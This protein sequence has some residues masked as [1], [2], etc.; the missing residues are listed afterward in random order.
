[1][2]FLDF[3]ERDDDR[4]D[5]MLLVILL[6]TLLKESGDLLFFTPLYTLLLTGLPLFSFVLCSPLD[7]IVT[8]DLFS[9]DNLDTIVLPPTTRSLEVIG[10][11]SESEPSYSS[12]MSWFLF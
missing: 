8:L 12:G 11:S 7:D 4:I 5:C 3:T 10:S 6:S 9:L 1:M 2:I